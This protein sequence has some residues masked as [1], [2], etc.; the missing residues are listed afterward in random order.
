[1]VLFGRINLQ[2]VEISSA[3]KGKSFS[4][5]VNKSQMFTFTVSWTPWK[6]FQ[7]ASILVDLAAHM[8]TLCIM[9]KFFFCVI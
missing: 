7:Y 9:I 2:A 4:E 5:N 3:I 8:L 6:R 1:M